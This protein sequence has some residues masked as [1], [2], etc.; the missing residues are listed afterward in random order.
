MQ[1]SLIA[2]V[3]N[4]SLEKIFSKSHTFRQKEADKTSPPVTEVNSQ[5]PGGTNSWRNN[6]ISKVSSS[7]ANDDV[8]L[9]TNLFCNLP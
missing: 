8:S 1:L 5:S 7:G 4:A 2:N 3:K 6:E 9:D